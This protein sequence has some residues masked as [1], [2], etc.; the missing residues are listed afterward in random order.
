MIL[1][2]ITGIL[3]FECGGLQVLFGLGLRDALMHEHARTIRGIT[4]T[5]SGLRA[6]GPGRVSGSRRVVLRGKREGQ[7]FLLCLLTVLL[8]RR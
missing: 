2:S 4:T 8:Y 6:R 7:P 3:C 1:Q 5:C